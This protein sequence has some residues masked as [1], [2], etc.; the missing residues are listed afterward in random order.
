MK[1]GKR[2]S[3]PGKRSKILILIAGLLIFAVYEAALSLIA[4]D[5]L[6]QYLSEN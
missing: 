6:N 2:K 5:K 3:V 4:Q 1:N